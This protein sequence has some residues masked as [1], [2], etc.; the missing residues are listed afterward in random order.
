M[1][2]KSSDHVKLAFLLCITIGL[3][4]YYPVPHSYEKLK[5]LIEG[6]NGMQTLDYF[7]LVLHNLPWVYFLISIGFWLKSRKKET[8]F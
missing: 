7:D 6:G 3:A 1:K 4:P 5:W 8:N 2:F